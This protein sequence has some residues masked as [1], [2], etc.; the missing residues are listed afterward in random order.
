MSEVEVKF[1][2]GMLDGLETKGKLTLDSLC[3][4]ELQVIVNFGKEEMVLNL[5]MDLV[6]R[7]IIKERRD[8]K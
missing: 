5:P 2:G 3:I 1:F 6:E 4:N 7:V 8:S